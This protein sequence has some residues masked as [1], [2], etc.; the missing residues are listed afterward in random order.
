MKTVICDHLIRGSRPGYPN[1]N[2]P[3][4]VVQ[5]WVDAAIA[6]GARSVLCLL[7]PSE[8]DGYYTSVPGGLLGVYRANGLTVAHLPVLDP[9]SDADDEK[10]RQGLAA[11]AAEYDR[12]PHPVLVHCSAGVVRTGCAVRH[13]LAREGLTPWDSEE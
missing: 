6:K 12:L 2:V 3:A 10:S 4:R 11:I 1:S 7:D 8:V 13:L 9:V 5:A